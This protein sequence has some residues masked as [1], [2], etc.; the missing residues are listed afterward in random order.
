MIE[1]GHGYGPLLPPNA[2]SKLVP[3]T[4]GGALYAIIGWLKE[5]ERADGAEPFRLKKA[6]QTV[7]ILNAGKARRRRSRSQSYE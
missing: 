2:P 1:T 4:A 7:I 5:R 6:M 3:Y